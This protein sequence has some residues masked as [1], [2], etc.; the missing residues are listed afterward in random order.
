[1]YVPIFKYVCV[2]VFIIC[3]T[4]HMG[5]YA[6]VGGKKSNNSVPNPVYTKLF[7]LCEIYTNTTINSHCCYMMKKALTLEKTVHITHLLPDQHY[8]HGFEHLKVF[9]TC[10][11]GWTEN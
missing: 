4:T 10:I 9:T 2:C 8:F 11:G 3:T 5:V 6:C 7:F 1:M